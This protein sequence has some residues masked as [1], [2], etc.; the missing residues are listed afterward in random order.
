MAF[1]RRYEDFEV[2]DM[3]KTSESSLSPVSGQ[4][5]HARGLH[6]MT[7]GGLSQGDQLN[8]VTKLAGE[9]NKQF[10]NRGGTKTTGAFR[11]QLHQ[12]AAACQALNSPAGQAALTLLDDPS[13]TA[14]KLRVTLT[15]ANITELAALSIAASTQGTS[16]TK[17]DATV[18]RRVATGVQVILDRDAGGDRL[19]IQTCY[20]LYQSA[21]ISAWEVSDKTNK[22]VIA[23]G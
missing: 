14:S 22:T 9:T 16:V 11:N 21:L 23:R 8:R 15:V 19:H 6:A 10:Q 7:P 18:S 20:P 17:G 1:V 2:R 12:A 3:L 13:H 4:Q 5:G